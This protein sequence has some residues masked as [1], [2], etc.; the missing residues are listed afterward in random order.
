MTR[1]LCY[2]RAMMT[3]FEKLPWVGERAPVVAVLRLNGVIGQVGGLRR[4]LA[5]ATL[6]ERLESAFKTRRLSA[7]ALGVNSPGGAPAQSAMIAKRIRDL[8]A[9]KDI[10]VFTFIEDVGASG[11]YWLACAG[12]EIFAQPSSIVGSI[13]VVSGGFGFADM[14][15]KLGIERRLH[16]SGD[17]KAMLDPFAPEKAAE[18]KHLKALQKEIHDDFI[19]MVRARRGDRLATTDKV[20]FSGAFW[21]GTKAL[22][23]G[24]IDGLGDLRSVMREKFGK[25][26]KFRNFDERRSW[27]QRR[28]SL[29][30][31]DAGI[32]ESMS[33]NLADNLL[34]AVEERLWWNRFGL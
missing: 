32:S 13:G 10:P 27:W 11:G 26:V 4:G 15:K 8:A 14:I 18:V 34:A 24:L 12:D 22:E 5:L 3:W 20:L 7:V 9:E 31:P 33:L 17:K 19:T 25:T 23:L 1:H 29:S 28:F 16:T 6:D 21:T 30:A 2:Y